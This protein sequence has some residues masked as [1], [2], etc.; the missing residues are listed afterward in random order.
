MSGKIYPIRTCFGC[1]RKEAKHNLMRLALD[2]NGG[3]TQDPGQR[4]DGRG[5]YIHP[6]TECIDRAAKRKLPRQIG[7]RGSGPALSGM[8]ER[9]TAELGGSGD[10]GVAK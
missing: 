10:K 1:G 8:L 6:T 3:V 9:M 7:V 5:V 4:S 2:S